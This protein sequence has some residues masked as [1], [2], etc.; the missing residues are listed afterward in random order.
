MAASGIVDLPHHR[1]GS[2]GQ[3][4]VSDPVLGYQ[5]KGFFRVKLPEAVR[6]DGDTV[7]PTVRST[8]AIFVPKE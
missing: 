7:M 2:W 4:G 5:M 3:E 6:Q 1:Q 8:E